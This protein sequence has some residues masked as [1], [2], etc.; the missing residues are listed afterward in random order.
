MTRA[1][2]ESYNALML[3][4]DE[5]H[6]KPF[7]GLRPGVWLS[8][9]YGAAILLILFFILIFPG[10]SRPGSVI[11]VK[12][13]PWGAAVRLDGVYR[14]TA[15]CEFFVPQGDHTLELV[16]PGFESRK[17]EG[18]VPGRIFFSLIFPRYV[19]LTETLK[20]DKPLAA[21]RD[22]AADYAAWTFAGE[23]TPAYQIPLS[24]SEGA[25][26]MGPTLANSEDHVAADELLQAAAAFAV[27]K[28]SLRDLIRAKT[29]IDNGGLS[30]SPLSLGRSAAD[31]LAWLS[32][33]PGAAVWL[34]ETL[35]QEASVLVINSAW[36][37]QQIVGPFLTETAASPSAGT[38]LTGS[39]L[40]RNFSAGGL[41]FREIPGGTLARPAAFPR[42][43]AVET[44]F[45]SETE[46]S[47]A[48]FA[49]FLSANPKWRLD[50]L[51]ELMEQ[52]LVTT[53]YLAGS[54][55]YS[56]NT[57]ANSAGIGAVSWYAA[58]AYCQWLTT[59]LPPSMAAWEVRLPTEAEWEYAAKLPDGLSGSGGGLWEWCAN[60]YTPL[61]F[62][63]LSA[64]AAEYLG[65][66]ERPV[67]GGSRINAGAPVNPETR[68]SLPPASCSPFVSFRPVIALR[69]NR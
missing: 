39:I 64:E 53:D 67:R 62:S 45:L 9:I 17:I 49:A 5:V 24:L 38:D 18:P 31:I 56:A 14:G 60:P 25:Y 43:Q 2:G 57:N 68:G 6:L 34:A 36:Y 29:L 15:P 42:N 1:K 44:F 61:N 33:N 47:P 12:T 51:P 20:I 66:P 55:D 48:A 32:A 59:Q 41:N 58:S 40:G 26:R 23:P 28:A 19:R 3:E 50:N 30:P 65:S 10:L 4:E 37:E 54:V 22:A 7:L 69:G 21:L 8:V 46:T 11:V 13:E 35:P 52:G 27:T 16:L 63:A